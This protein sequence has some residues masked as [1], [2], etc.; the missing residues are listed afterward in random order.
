MANKKI[1]PVVDALKELYGKLGGTP[2]DVE[3][4]STTTE[5]IQEITEVASPGGGGGGSLIVNFHYDSME[6]DGAEYET[7]VG[8][9]TF[10]EVFNAFTSG[11]NV[12]GKVISEDGNIDI[13]SVTSAIKEIIPSDEPGDEY[14]MFIYFV[15]SYGV[16]TEI[17]T[18][19]TD[20][21]INGFDASVFNQNIYHIFFD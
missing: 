18:T 13:Y 12:I 2:E 14:R 16:D 5:I 6:V 9:K 3:D 8:D 11:Q 19:Y 7:M 15:S 20:F 17:E 4:I 21:V 1:I 10:N